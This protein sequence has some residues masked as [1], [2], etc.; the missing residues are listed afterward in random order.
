MVLR[1]ST[2]LSTDIDF[3]CEDSRSMRQSYDL[4]WTGLLSFIIFCWR[5]FKSQNALAKVVDGHMAVGIIE[6]TLWD[7]LALI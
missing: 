4:P 1:S 2:L 7:C 3:A 5:V 6:I